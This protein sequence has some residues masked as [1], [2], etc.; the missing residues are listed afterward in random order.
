LGNL[1]SSGPFGLKPKYGFAAA[2]CQVMAAADRAS[3]ISFLVLSTD[4]VEL[5]SVLQHCSE[6]ARRFI[7]GETMNTVRLIGRVIVT[8]LVLGVLATPGAAE[9]RKVQMKIAGYLCGN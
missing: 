9:I 8:T 4:Y 3:E 6:T 7:Q 2:P 5:L 1:E